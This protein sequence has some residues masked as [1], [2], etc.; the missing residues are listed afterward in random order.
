[1]VERAVQTLKDLIIANLEDKIGLSK[2]IN[3]ALRV[4]R[5]TTHTGL[6]V[7]PFGLHHGKNPRTK[8]TKKIKG[9]KSYLSDWITLNASVPPIQIPIYLARNGEGYVTDHM[10]VAQKRK[11]PCCA[12]HR[13]PK[14][15]PVKPV[16]ENFQYPYTFFQRRNQKKS[17]EEKYQEQP[18]IARDGTEHTVR[19]ADKKNFTDIKYQ[20]RLIFRYHRRKTCHQTNTI[21]G[22]RGK[23]RLLEEGIFS[24]S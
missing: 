6:K 11:T 13:S 8:L 21:C 7:K 24:E 19:T 3:R 22:D 1:M 14:T 9:N 12:S 2:S 23:T 17:L 20:H 18:T 16:S 15:I 4:M 5:F 10:V